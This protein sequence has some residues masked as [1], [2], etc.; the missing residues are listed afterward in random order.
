M[1]TRVGSNDWLERIFIGANPQ[2][3]G[4]QRFMNLMIANAG[5]RKD[6]FVFTFN[7]ELLCY[8]PRDQHMQGSRAQLRSHFTGLAIDCSWTITSISG[9]SGCLEREKT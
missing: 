8:I 6:N 3:D 5:L 4:T 1:Q 2:E 9:E 7:R